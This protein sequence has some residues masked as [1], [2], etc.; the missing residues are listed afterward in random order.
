MSLV[1]TINYTIA[2]ATPATNTVIGRWQADGFRN[3]VVA[4]LPAGTV[5]FTIKFVKSNQDTL[6]DFTAAATLTNLWEYAEVIDLENGSDI[7]GSTGV[8]LS[9]T[10]TRSFEYNNNTAKWVGIMCT[11]YTTGT[12]S[13]NVLLS[14]NQ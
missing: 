7:N 10:T 12:I 11:T 9:A 13:G 4:L 2:S 6:P 8:P 3:I 1:N 5:N 14:N